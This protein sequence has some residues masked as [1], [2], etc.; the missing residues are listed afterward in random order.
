MCFGTVQAKMFFST[1]VSIYVR[2]GCT[3]PYVGI[4]SSTSQQI[5][6]IPESVSRLVV[7]QDGSPG[8]GSGPGVTEEL[9]LCVQERSEGPVTS[10][11]QVPAPGQL[12]PRAK[13]L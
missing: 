1:L 2:K 5:P 8:A 9:R 4:A 10:G 11:V 6:D 7:G 13:G 12:R 3:S